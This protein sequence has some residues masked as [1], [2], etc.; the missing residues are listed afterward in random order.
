MELQTGEILV[1]ILV[2]DLRLR[3]WEIIR[4]WNWGVRSSSIC[5]NYA[6]L[7][8]FLSDSIPDPTE[9]ESHAI[10]QK[11]VCVSVQKNRSPES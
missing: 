9:L 2:D 11:D 10:R 4:P 5:L 1:E 6:N 3:I 7:T 8:W